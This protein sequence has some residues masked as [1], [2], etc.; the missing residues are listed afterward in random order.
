MISHLIEKSYFLNPIEIWQEWFVINW[1]FQ[2]TENDFLYGTEC[3]QL[4]LEYT[5]TKAKLIEGPSNLW[6]VG[7]EVLSFLFV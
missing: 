6:K 1:L 7:I 5:G 2:A 4:A 3:L